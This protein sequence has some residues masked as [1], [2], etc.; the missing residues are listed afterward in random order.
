MTSLYNFCV[1]TAENDML[2]ANQ[3]AASNVSVSQG[4]S[5]ISSAEPT[6]ETSV[7]PYDNNQPANPDLW[8]GVFA[9][10]SLLGVD[11]F[12]SYDTQNIICSLMCIGTFIKQHPLGNKLIKDFPNLAEVSFA[13]WYLINTIYELGWN[14]LSADNNEKLIQQ[15]VS[16]CF[17]K[18]PKVMLKPNMSLSQNS[19]KSKENNLTTTTTRKSYAQASKIN[20]E[21][22]IHIKNSFPTLSPKKIIEVSNILNKSSMVKPKI[23]MTTKGPLRKQVIILMNLNNSNIIGS[24]AIFHIND[25]NK[26]LKDA[27][28]NNSADF[29]HIDKVGIIVTI[30][31]IVSEQDMRTIET[32]IK[33]SEKIN[34]DFVKSPHLPQSKSYLKILGLLY[35]V[36]NMNEPIT[37][38]I[39]KEVLKESH[40]FKDIEFSSKPQVIKASPNSDSAVI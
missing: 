8:N 16:E 24:N 40:I 23:K 2:A 32:A 9:P 31:F 1:Q 7:L 30:R 22:I 15:S 20:V 37:S 10:T 17:A 14:R 34:K 39:V 19:L 21:D 29:I 33:N 13:I 3:P 5:P 11:K 26:H 18:T 28:S 38:Q 35:F 27:N 12:Q 6:L 4:N 36:K 25:I